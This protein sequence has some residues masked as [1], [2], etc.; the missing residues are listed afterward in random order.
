[1]TIPNYITVARILLIP[2]FVGALLYD[3][4]ESV[5]GGSWDLYRWTAVISFFVAS[6]S[7]A[8]DGW[9]AR[10]FNQQSELGAVLDPLADKALIVSAVITLGFV[11]LPGFQELPLWFVILVLSRDVILLASFVIFHYLNR[12]IKVNP[13][14]TGKVATFLLM[15]S[16]CWV[17]LDLRFLPLYAVVIPVGLFHFLSLVVY[18]HGAFHPVEVSDAC[19]T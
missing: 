12:K 10:T 13:H 5:D 8:L 17:L 14:W 15:A 1:M 11:D 6:I 4:R 9:I 16:L 2:V 3:S 19:E 7:D 18:A